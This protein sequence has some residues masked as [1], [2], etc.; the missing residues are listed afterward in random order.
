MLFYFSKCAMQ[1]DIAKQYCCCSMS[2]LAD[3]CIFNIANFL[4]TATAVVAWSPI[5]SLLL[6][7]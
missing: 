7:K 5:G 3:H 4:A 1:A 6:S 2:L